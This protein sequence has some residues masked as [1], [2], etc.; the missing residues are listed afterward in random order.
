MTDADPA[1]ASGSVLTNAD[2]NADVAVVVPFR[3]GGPMLIQACRSLQRQSHRHWQALLVND[4]SD[5]ASVQLAE[6]LVAGDR[7]FQLLHVPQPRDIAGPWLARNVGVAAAPTSLVAFLDADD[8]WHPDKLERQLLLHGSSEAVLSV[9][10]YHRFRQTSRGWQV[11]RT[12]MPPA[13]LDL[14][15][16]LR[17]N[18]LPLSSVVVATALLKREIRENGDPAS[19]P[20]WPEHHED[21]GLWLRLFARQSDLRY[22]CLPEALMAYRLHSSS[23]SAQRW[24]S[25]RSVS[26]LLARHSRHRLHHGLL[27]GRW[28]ASRLGEQ[29]FG[30]RPT[31]DGRLL[32]QAFSELLD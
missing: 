17:G 26:R 6:A 22:R 5:P 29:L 2:V 27:L 15:Q 13:H 14:A 7:R 19:G 12:R 21:Y 30:S 32:P 1:K 18:V 4:G 10:G 24:R 25:H 16:L 11:M 28:A 23:I 31:R 9:S 8:L 3:N 20:F